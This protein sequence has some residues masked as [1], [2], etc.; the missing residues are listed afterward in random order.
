V[1]D[2]RIDY[3]GNVER[4]LDPADAER[5][6]DALLAETSRRSRSA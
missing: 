4:P 5:A 3:Q 1:V 6:V 2:E